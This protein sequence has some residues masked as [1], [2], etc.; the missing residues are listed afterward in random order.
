[1]TTWLRTS[2]PF[3]PTNT[4]SASS[5][6]A[7]I[8]DSSSLLEIGSQIRPEDFSLDSHRRIFRRMIE[9]SEE[10]SSVDLVSLMHVLE[11]HGEM[12]AIGGYAYLSDLT[13]GLPRNPKFADYLLIVRDKALRRAILAACEGL[14]GRAYSQDQ[15]SLEI[16]SWGIAALSAAAE[17]GQ[18]K[19]EVFDADA[20]A[21]EAQIRLIDH[22]EDS[23]ALP[24]G[25]QALD[26]QTGGGIRLGELWVIGAAPSR[27]KTT[28]ARQIAQHTVARGVPA[29][30]H[31]GEMTKES[32][33]EVTA[34]LLEGMQA[35][36]TRDPKT[37]NAYER[38]QLALG[39]RRLSA[40]PL[41][42][43][44]TGGIQLDRL[45]WNAA[46]Q[47]RK[48]G[49]KLFVVDY[50]QIVNA[51]GRDDRQ[52]V[53]A[54]AYKLRQFAKDENIATILLSQSP[55]PEGRS[56]NSRPNMF[57]LKESGALEEAAHVVL[58]PYRPMDAETGRFT[59]QDE[60]IIGK[61]RW[62]AIDSVPVTLN[63][64]YLRF[65]PR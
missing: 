46:R 24:T 42:I 58:L 39:L 37:M 16:A 20:L 50:A 59:G 40:M 64:K 5:W 13:S 47:K 12:K 51:P 38:D 45:L 19:E 57:S 2:T 3:P 17:G 25:L 33:F 62:G 54:V 1:M 28:L 29:Y 6:E 10:F 21:A 52:R 8:Q 15:P 30:V 4:P 48:Q 49:I 53:T 34:C 31:S 61:N 22:P 63:G 32:W 43:S 27:G 41:S 60:I 55:R 14:S 35:W 26:E 44:D 36:K 11:R 56:V 23:P 18:T 7:V 9:T 65:D